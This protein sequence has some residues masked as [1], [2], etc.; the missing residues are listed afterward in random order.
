MR[1]HLWGRLI[2]WGA[3]T[4]IVLLSHSIA[5]RADEDDDIIYDPPPAEMI[6]SS[7][8][9]D[10]SAAADPAL[11]GSEW[12]G[13]DDGFDESS[14]QPGGGAHAPSHSGITHGATLAPTEKGT[15]TGL[16]D[17]APGDLVPVSRLVARPKIL[18]PLPHSG[19]DSASL[20]V[21]WE[22]LIKAGYD[23]SFSTPTGEAAQL[24]GSAAAALRKTVEF[25]RPLAYSTVYPAQFAGIFLPTLNGPQSEAFLKSPILLA[26]VAEFFDSGRP[27]AALG[28]GILLASRSR[29]RVSG[30]S[31]L[32]E[33]RTAEPPHA[34]LD[35]KAAV[36]QKKWIYGESA[37]FPIR[38]GQYLSARTPWLAVGLVDQFIDALADADP[39][40]T[41]VLNYPLTDAKHHLQIKIGEYRPS[42][43]VLGDIL[44][45][46]EPGQDY[47][48]Y[49]WAFR[50]WNLAGFRVVSFAG[51]G[52]AH[53]AGPGKIFGL[54]RWIEAK[55]RAE[56]ARPLLLAAGGPSAGAW[57]TAWNA[58]GSPRRHRFRA[59]PTRA[60]LLL[61]PVSLPAK[62]QIPRGLPIFV[63]SPSPSPALRTSVLRLR[64]NGNPSSLYLECPSSR[65]NAK[66]KLLARSLQAEI[67]ALSGAFAVRTL[68]EGAPLESSLLCHSY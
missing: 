10:S 66:G 7:G 49:R 21:I 11:Q 36:G 52:S 22:R 50:Q 59:R 8:L 63:S 40:H 55:T 41:Q 23:V 57:I 13:S 45:F 58:E 44:F 54:G 14:G 48:S 64:A 32:F 35:F 4:Q 68:A 26:D 37:R 39:G 60:W 19:V 42:G 2:A 53:S 51:Q 47:K 3:L 34:P 12:N 38:D 27:V 46:P 15:D 1:T 20:L 16:D 62:G 25:K 31:S 6:D 61:S 17:S 28:Q 29:S 24:S 67:S 65:G 9:T 5:L 43:E 33:R 18:I 56:N 30:R